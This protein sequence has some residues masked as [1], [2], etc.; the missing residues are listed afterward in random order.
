[1]QPA[2]TPLLAKGPNEAAGIHN[3]GYWLGDRMAANI[4][5]AAAESPL[6]RVGI[7]AFF[8]CPTPDSPSW[9]IWVTR[10]LTELGWIAGQTFVSECVS[11]VG[12]LDQLPALARELVSRRPDVLA[13]ASIALIKALK[14]E[15]TTIPI[16]M[17]GLAEPV[18][19]G[20]VT[21]L[22]RPEGNVTSKYSPSGSN[23]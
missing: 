2:P 10:R 11:T 3:V 14:Q 1:M 15:T 9:D 18:R 5:C 21:N 16:V 19:T 8:G 12:R 23:F 22:A 17:L 4:L 13:A 7:L 6:K 20:I